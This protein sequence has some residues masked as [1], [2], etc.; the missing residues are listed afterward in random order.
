MGEQVEMLEHH[1][2]LL[3]VLVYIQ[4]FPVWA[5]FLGNIHTLKDYAAGGRLLQQ[6]QRAQQSGLAGAGGAD[7]HHHI[8]LVYIHTDPVQG[9]YSAFVIIFLEVFDLNKFIAYRHDSSS[10]QNVLSPCWLGR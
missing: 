10:F 1:A 9:L 4:L 2:H 8:A 5:F 3:P 7:N 6:V